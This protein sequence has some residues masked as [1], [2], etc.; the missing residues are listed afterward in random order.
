MR[1]ASSISTGRSISNVY[2]NN[3]TYIVQ[4]LLSYSF[5][6]SRFVQCESKNPPPLRF[7]DI[8]F[9]NGWKCLI[10]F[11]H[12]L[13]V[14]FCTR[15]Q[16]FIQLTSTLTK[17]CHTKRDHPITFKY[18]CK[19]NLLFQHNPKVLFFAAEE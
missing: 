6:T 1:T 17:L 13:N 9:L 15:L 2:S 3:I 12:L 8:F 18:S 19:H 10:N 4:L 11:S 16:I 14:P 5:H 7:S